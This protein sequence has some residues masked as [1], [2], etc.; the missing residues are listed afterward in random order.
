M[1]MIRFAKLNRN[2]CVKRVQC[3][4]EFEPR[5]RFADY[6]NVETPFEY[7]CQHCKKTTFI[8]ELDQWCE[9]CYEGEIYPYSREVNNK[10]KNMDVDILNQKNMK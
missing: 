1:E 7:P 2:K 8:Q 6:I 9:E 10:I 5:V 3:D 4:W